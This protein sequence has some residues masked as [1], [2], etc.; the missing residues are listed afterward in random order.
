MYL[1]KAMQKRDI[2]NLLSIPFKILVKKIE[3][4]HKEEQGSGRHGFSQ[5]G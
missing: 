5:L 3:K 1:T 2:Q 4:I